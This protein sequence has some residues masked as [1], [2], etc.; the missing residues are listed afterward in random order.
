VMGANPTVKGNNEIYKQKLDGIRASRSN[1]ILSQNLIHHNEGDGLRI[2][3]GANPTVKGN[4]IFEN[5]R[6]GIHV[7][8]EGNGICSDNWISANKNAGFQIY[9]GS[10]TKI[11]NNI[12]Q[13]NRCTGIY[14]SDRA[15]VSIENNEISENG[16]C[17]MEIISGVNISLCEGNSIHHNKNAGFAVYADTN[18]TNLL[19]VNNVMSNGSTN[20]DGDIIAGG[21]DLLLREGRAIYPRNYTG[22]KDQMEVVSFLAEKAIMTKQCTFTF[23][24]EYYHAQYWYECRTCSSPRQILGRPEVSVCEYC[25]K[26][27]HAGHELS[28]RKFG[29]FYCDCESSPT[30]CKCLG[31]ENRSLKDS[32]L[33]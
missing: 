14:V 27:C 33:C 3:M 17:G 29:H 22:K 5:N 28:A 1:P 8:R 32:V 19:Q 25:A 4:K 6:V 7:Y 26:T 15:T 9:G 18:L 24:R 31:G 10:T 13:Q 20:E 23:T 2:V 16:D 12:I 21:G 30:S 11:F